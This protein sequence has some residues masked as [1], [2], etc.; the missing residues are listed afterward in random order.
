MP[1]YRKKPIVIEARQITKDNILEVVKWCA[2]NSVKTFYFDGRKDH[3]YVEIET[4]EGTMRADTGDWIIQ[5]VRGEFY[6]CKP[7][8][9]AETYEEA[10]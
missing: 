5:G 2:G 1:K 7:D 4:P 8:I 9:F 6:P 3:V 10:E